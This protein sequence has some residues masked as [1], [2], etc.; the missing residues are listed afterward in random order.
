MDKNTVVEDFAVVINL[1]VTGFNFGD[2]A[3][4]TLNF[5]VVFI[6]FFKC[7]EFVDTVAGLLEYLTVNR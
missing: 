3:L 7:V 1:G 5:L 6:G 2:F 4:Q